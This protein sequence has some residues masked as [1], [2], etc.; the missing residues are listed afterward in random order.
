L[1]QQKEAVEL[2]N[3]ELE[4]F[5]YSVSHDLRS[6]L[7]CIDAFSRIVLEDCGP[8]LGAE[9]RDHIQR[10]RHAAQQMTKL[11]EELL[12]LARVTRSEMRH[13]EVALT[14]LA[15]SIADQLQASQPERDVTF[16]TDEDIRGYGDA[17]L[18]GVVLE[19]LLGNAWKFTSKRAHAEIRFG[20]MVRDG[21]PTYFV[22]DNG[23]GFDMAYAP[24]LFAPF[25]RLHSAQEFEGTGVGLATVQRVVQRHDGRVWAESK[26]DGGAT[27][28]FTLG[29]G[30]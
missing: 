18:L 9:G 24:K 17:T 29:G 13:G 21:K 30:S 20:R 3:Q 1:R 10:I 6:P 16:I 26:I 12:A 14:A 27:F 22:R 19:N 5:S 4:S 15:R 28:Y 23:A 25:Q 7:R 8:A 11:I 2:A